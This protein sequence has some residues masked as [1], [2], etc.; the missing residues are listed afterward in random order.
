MATCSCEL[1]GSFNLGTGIISANFKS[2]VNFTVT[3][4]GLVLHGPAMGDI[5]ITAYAPLGSESLSCAGR[6]GTSF[7]WV[8]KSECDSGAIV[9]HFIPSGVAKAYTEGSVTS[10]ISMQTEP[11]CNVYDTFSASA[12]SGPYTPIVRFS[13]EDGYNMTYNGSPIVVSSASNEE[14]SSV[15]FLTSILP[16][17]SKLYMTNFS[18][19][20]TPPNIPV[21]NYS[22]I[23]SY[24]NC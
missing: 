24:V 19:T 18:W 7:S 6:A 21:V 20:Y 16:I 9:V 3:E 15:S 4:G 2:N 17:G 23:F 5:S 1:A 10:R 8:Q 22:F 14:A 11:L 12:S 13:H